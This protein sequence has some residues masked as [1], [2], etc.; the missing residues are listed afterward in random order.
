MK[1]KEIILKKINCIYYLICYYVLSMG[2]TVTDMIISNYSNLI[3]NI[4]LNYYFYYSVNLNF[5]G[6]AKKV[7]KNM[8]LPLAVS[9]GVIV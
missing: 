6:Y 2:V 1:S 7:G 3:T 8:V 9:F 4:N 5:V